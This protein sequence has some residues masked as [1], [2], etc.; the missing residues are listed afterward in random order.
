MLR[1]GLPLISGEASAF[2]RVT[3]VEQGRLLLGLAASVAFLIVALQFVDLRDLRRALDVAPQ[4]PVTLTAALSAYTG[5]FV[6]R[7]LAWRRLLTT[8][9]ATGRL[10]SILQ[11]SLFLNHLLP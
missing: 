7:A 5:A 1:R 8:P 2:H 10:F 4:Q 9:I 6:L 3:R 11:A